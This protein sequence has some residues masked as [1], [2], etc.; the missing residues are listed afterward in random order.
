MSSPD[1]H[2]TDQLFCEN[3]SLAQIIEDD[4]ITLRMPGDYP[5]SFMKDKESACGITIR[6]GRNTPHPI[7]A[8]CYRK[9]A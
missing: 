3:C 4:P 8:I 5:F 9:Q 6:L 2:I 7:S 1:D